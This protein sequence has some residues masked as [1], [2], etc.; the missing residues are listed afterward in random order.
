MMQCRVLS[1]LLMCPSK[2]I[3]CPPPIN[4][5]NACGSYS[6]IHSSEEDNY[7]VVVMSGVDRVVDTLPTTLYI[8]RK[9]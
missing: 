9:W 8:G 3:D 5:P 7:K 1:K 2:V 4:Y 6:P